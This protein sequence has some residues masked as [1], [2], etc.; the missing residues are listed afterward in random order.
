MKKGTKIIVVQKNGATEVYNTFSQIE[1]RFKIPAHFFYNQ[2]REN[3]EQTKFIK[4]DLEINIVKF[5]HK[6]I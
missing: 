1:K 5:K 4:N 6:Y 2:R 3:K